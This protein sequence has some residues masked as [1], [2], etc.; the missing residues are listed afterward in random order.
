MTLNKHTIETNKPTRKRFS[1][2]W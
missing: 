2:K 1:V